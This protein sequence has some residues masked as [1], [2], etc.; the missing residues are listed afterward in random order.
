MIVVQRIGLDLLREIVDVAHQHALPVVGQ[1]WR[2]DAAEAAKAGIDQ[3]DN[4]SRIAASRVVSGE[5][6]FDYGL[7]SERLAIASRLWTTIDWSERS[8]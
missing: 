8:G 3:L 1:I 7:V 2:M 4:S 6:L 5:A